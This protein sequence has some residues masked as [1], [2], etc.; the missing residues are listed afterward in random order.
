MPDFIDLLITN[1]DITLD[2]GG[3]PVMVWDRPS[4]AQDIMHMIRES[5]L[6][7]GIIA[8][9]DIRKRKT[10]IVRLSLMVDEDARIVPGSTEISESRP[11]EYRLTAITVNY[12][13][14]SLIL[15]TG[16]NPQSAPSA[17]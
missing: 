14:L 12:G 2:A 8:E 1:D 7:V 9:R 16:F 13:P 4:I 15:T 5:G 10:N 11:G 17:N 3:I 6:L